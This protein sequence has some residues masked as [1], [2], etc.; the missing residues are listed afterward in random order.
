MTLHDA[1]ALAQAHL[2]E[3][4]RTGLTPDDY[5]YVLSEPVE[6]A[7]CYYF[8][9]QLCHRFGLPESQWEIFAGAPGF[10]VNRQ[11]GEVSVVSWGELP[12]LPQQS[13]IWQHSRQRAAELAR[14]PLSLATLRRYLPLPLPELAAFYQQLRQPEM[15]QKQREAALLAQLLLAAGIQV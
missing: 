12:Q 9:Y 13:A 10:A 4:N 3:A 7:H 2:Q 14:T 11:T 6:Y 8:D 5:E 1:S 15:Q